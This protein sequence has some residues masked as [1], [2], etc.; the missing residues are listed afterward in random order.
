V[1]DIGDVVNGGKGVERKAQNSCGD[2]G[3]DE[4]HGVSPEKVNIGL[5]V[6]SLKL[7]NRASD[8]KLRIGRRKRCEG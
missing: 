3:F 2:G 8:Y 6:I 7:F 1:G 4:F 5:E